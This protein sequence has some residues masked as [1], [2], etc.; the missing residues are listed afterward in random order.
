[1]NFLQ[2]RGRSPFFNSLW[3]M[4][5]VRREGSLG[6][7]FHGNKRA[8]D[9]WTVEKPLDWDPVEAG[10]KVS[11]NHDYGRPDQPAGKQAAKPATPPAPAGKQ[12]AGPARTLLA[13]GAQAAK[14]SGAD[15]GGQE[16]N[17]PNAGQGQK[18]AQEPTP[19]KSRSSAQDA[20][21]LKAEEEFRRPASTGVQFLRGV[22]GLLRE[23]GLNDNDEKPRSGASGPRG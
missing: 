3:V 4:E 21:K 10:R 6:R 19:T 12:P 7:K 15:K 5:P 22:T 23:W 18:T 16:A 8:L 2:Q 11:L 9:W 17:S 14:E 20:A 1:M 13:M